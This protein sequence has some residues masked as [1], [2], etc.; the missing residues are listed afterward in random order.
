[1]PPKLLKVPKITSVKSGERNKRIASPY[2]LFCKDKRPEVRIANP[3]ATFGQIGK[4]LGS[5]WAD[6]DQETK[7]RYKKMAEELKITRINA[8]EAFVD[9]ARIGEIEVMMNCLQETKIHVDGKNEQGWTAL[10]LAAKD[11]CI[12][13]INFLLTQ[14]CNVDS[15]SKDG[16][17]SL[18]LAAGE[19]HNGIC[20]LLLSRDCSID[21]QNNV[22]S[23]ALI[24]A[25][26]N[27]HKEIIDLLLARGCNLNIQDKE[28]NSALISAAGHHEICTSLIY[29]GADVN[30]Q[31]GKLYTA[32][33]RSC[34]MGCIPVAI[35]LIE[36][37]CDVSLRDKNGQTGMDWLRE[38]YPD[39]LEEVQVR[40]TYL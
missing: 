11:G 12:D 31:N 7:D 24:L 40:L 21:T 18:M 28:G 23:T 10:T 20:E 29:C 2:L 19:G 4:L 32:F 17:S 27:G 16:S 8:L 37:G 26:K 35:S 34:A 39:K 33:I 22:G 6:T 13:A 15:L 1:M 9:A 30:I 36:A 38:Y 14:N 25:A 3:D 5:L